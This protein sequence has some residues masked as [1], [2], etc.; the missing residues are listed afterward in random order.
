MTTAGSSGESAGEREALQEELRATVRRRREAGEYP[1]DLERDLEAHFQRMVG[2]SAAGAD[3]ER[4]LQAVDAA[5]QVGRHR[6]TTD[7]RLPGGSALH[8]AVARAVARQTDGVLDQVREFAVAVRDLLH[9]VADRLPE[10]D[11]RDVA[12][13]VD[14]I[15]DRIAAYE[16]MPATADPLARELATRMEALETAVARLSAA[17][18]PVGVAADTAGRRALLGDGGGAM[19]DLDEQS[20]VDGFLILEAADDASLDTVALLQNLHGYGV[21]DVSRLVHIAASRLRPGGRLLLR[22]AEAPGPVAGDG[23]A[24]WS[25]GVGVDTLRTWCLEAGFG[26]VEVSGLRPYTL[27]ARR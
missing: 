24:L 6:I 16:R 19:L 18:G 4:Q 13:R 2:R 8:T 27:V 22:G 21:A 25:A 20:N 14:V 12:A 9:T 26:D 10:D 3:I 1:P 7:S 15:L 17:H 5:A 23:A 11:M